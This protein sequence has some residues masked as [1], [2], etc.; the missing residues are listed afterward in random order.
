M[1]SAFLQCSILVADCGGGLSKRWYLSSKDPSE[2]ILSCSAA[3]DGVGLVSVGAE[4]PI[5]PLHT[6]SGHVEFICLYELDPDKQLCGES[7]I[8]GLYG[9]D[10][11]Y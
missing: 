11:S 9:D 7:F 4:V 8:R 1:F 3:A 5:R 2:G 6:C 10:I